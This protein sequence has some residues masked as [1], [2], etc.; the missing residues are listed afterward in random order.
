MHALCMRDG[1]RSTDIRLAAGSVLS[2]DVA[3][4]LRERWD[5][6]QVKTAHPI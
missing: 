4:V 6:S 3:V 1:V 5:A 2:P